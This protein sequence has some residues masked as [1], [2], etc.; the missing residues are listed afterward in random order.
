MR[1]LTILTGLTAALLTTVP[2][3]LA[4]SASR[5]EGTWMLNP[6]RSKFSPG[7]PP[8]T[9]TLRWEAVAGGLKFTTDVVNAD[10]ETIHT[11]TFEASDGREG[12][13]E[14]ADTQVTRALKRIN[15]RTYEDVDRNNNKIMITRRLQISRDGKT[16]T[17]TAKGV[18]DHGEVVSD[19]VVYEKQ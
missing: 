13:V 12:N 8:K 6:A 19:V 9:A 3:L 5:L 7:P 1:R 2:P 14:G 15:D 10:G 4:Q 18:N 16:L 17:I 11:E